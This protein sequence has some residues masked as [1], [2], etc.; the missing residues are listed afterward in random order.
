MI[1]KFLFFFVLLLPQVG[2]CNLIMERINSGGFFV[3]GSIDKNNLVPYQGQPYGIFHVNIHETDDSFYDYQDSSADY[4]L[5]S[6]EDVEKYMNDKLRSGLSVTRAGPF[7]DNGETWTVYVTCKSGPN[8]AWIVREKVAS[9]PPGRISCSVSH[10]TTVSFGSVT[11]GG[12]KEITSPVSIR[13]TYPA[14]ATVTM[15]K[16]TV[17]LDDAV[18]NYYFPGDRKYFS[19]R[20]K[21]F[22]STDFNVRYALE[23]TGNTLGYK[24]GS[25]VMTVNWQ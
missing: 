24:S 9:M 16:S 17:N 13:C 15:S 5:G 22:Y 4:C 23:G 1:N 12:R 8:T 25:A 6:K 19:A 11:L 14:D 10:P 2:H 7:T 18:V 21:K 20:V 3:R